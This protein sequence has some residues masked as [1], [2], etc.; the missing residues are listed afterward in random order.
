M[1]GKRDRQRSLFAAGP[2]LGS[3]AL[4]RLGFY[5]RL[6]SEGPKHFPD[7]MF[8]SIYCADNGRPSVPPSLLCLARL[9]QFHDGV[10]DAEA[11]ERCRYDL[12]WKVAL[13]LDPLSIE[14]PF[15]K[16]TFQAFRARL[17]LH[18]R[19][20][21]A[22]EA[23]V[24]AARKAGLLSKTLRVALDSSPVRGR[25][26]VKDTFNLLSDAIVAI[27]R[28]VSRK[29]RQTAEEIAQA[30]GLERHFEAPS[31]KGSVDVD[32]SDRACVSNFLAG[33]LEDCEHAV[34]AAEE[35]GCATEEVT[36]LRKILADDVDRSDDGAP[37]LRRGVA[38]G[39]TVSVQDPQMR[40]GRKSSGH[41]YDGHKA[42]LAVEVDSGIITAVEMS[43]PGHSDGCHVQSLLE[44]TEQL[45]DAKVTQALGDSAYSTQT[46][47]AQA[48]EVGVELRTKMPASRRT[49]LYGPGDFEVSEDG[50]VA[51]CPAGHASAR[52][53][54]H[55]SRGTVH[56]WSQQTCRG[57]LRKSACTQAARRTLSVPPYFHDLRD[58]ER[59]AQS[60]EGRKLLRRRIIVE[61][62]LARLKHL[63]AGTARYFGRSKSKA[64]W[65]WTAAVANF[66]RVWSQPA[67][68]AT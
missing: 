52:H 24:K 7:E 17:T 62:A 34:Q 16:S 11:V 25:G 15:A 63:G 47:V 9:L 44:R 35:A 12:R 31:V 56:Y 37:R 57:C 22:F 55:G 33:L 1:L 51:R 8:A 53:Y 4:R 2:Q 68:V 39:R 38:K 50:Q 28:A 30:A 46:A 18:A 67:T 14:A 48:H 58:R 49:G 13:D 61:H 21:V 66:S 3:E 59:H 32:W 36:L 26:A 45:A 54:T 20:G 23:S 6:A 40:H 65:G 10:S 27:V 5:S 29:R 41:R 43:S 64:Q 19:E 42:H 60:P